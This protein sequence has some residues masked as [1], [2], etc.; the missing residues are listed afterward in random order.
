MFLQ[1]IQLSENIQSHKLPRRYYTVTKR[2]AVKRSSHQKQWQLEV[3][4]K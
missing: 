1:T 4:R 2:I 3:D